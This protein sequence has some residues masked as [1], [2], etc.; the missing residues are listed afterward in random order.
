MFF[1]RLDGIK[2][3]LRN[4]HVATEPLINV[5][6]SWIASKKLAQREGPAI[7]VAMLRAQDMGLLTKWSSEP[8]VRSLR[9][10]EWKLFNKKLPD[11]TRASQ[12]IKLYWR[13]CCLHYPMQSTN[14]MPH[15][16]LYL[17]SVGINKSI[18]TRKMSTTKTESLKSVD[19]DKKKKLSINALKGVFLVWVVGISVSIVAFFMELVV[20]GFFRHKPKPRP[21]SQF[22]FQYCE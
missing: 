20:G 9:E 11:R 17:Q 12:H 6:C 8:L 16:L 1:F 15:I 18:S 7:A 14:W 21:H 2:R 10:K 13:G 5:F 3:K 4:Y 22:M 19:R